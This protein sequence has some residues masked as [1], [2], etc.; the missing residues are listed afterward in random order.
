MS[1]VRERIWTSLNLPHTQ[2]HR[3]N[4]VGH[5]ISFVKKFQALKTLVVFR[6][7]K[8]CQNVCE[9]AFNVLY[10]NKLTKTDLMCV[11]KFAHTSH[12]TLKITLA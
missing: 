1:N 12:Y 9:R 5:T 10:E 3:I 4:N 11:G 2:G 7:M 8:T 6:R